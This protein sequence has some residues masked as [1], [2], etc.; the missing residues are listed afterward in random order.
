[1]GV[2]PRAMHRDLTDKKVFTSKSK[3]K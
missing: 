3:R 1:M 2:A